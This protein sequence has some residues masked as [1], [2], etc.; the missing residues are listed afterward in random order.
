MPPRSGGHKGRGGK[1]GES[2]TETILQQHSGFAR[3]FCAVTEG[4]TQARGVRVWVER[5][6]SI[7]GHPGTSH[8]RNRVGRYRGARISGPTDS[9]GMVENLHQQKQASPGSRAHYM[10]TNKKRLR[11]F[12]CNLLKSLA[13]L[14]RLER[15]TY[16]L[17]VRCSI[18]LS[19][20]RAVLLIVICYP[21]CQ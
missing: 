1:A 11:P 6:K 17:E 4:R 7:V 18:Q 8:C 19:Y 5:R 12:D 13:R 20:R 9:S 14:G 10:H 16:G 3:I 21:G 15:S 2:G